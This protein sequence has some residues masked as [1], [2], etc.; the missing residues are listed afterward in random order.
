M[1]PI[2]FCIL[3]MILPG[4][5]KCSVLFRWKCTTCLLYLWC[6]NVVFLLSL[7]QWLN[8]DQEAK[9]KFHLHY[10]P[11]CFSFFSFLQWCSHIL[12]LLMLTLSYFKLDT[13]YYIRYIYNKYLYKTSLTNFSLPVS[14]NTFAVTTGKTSYPLCPFSPFTNS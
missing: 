7:A 6:Q 10:P 4:L 13:F 12:L 11:T 1:I 5:G 14:F 9:S 3:L 2:E 8:N